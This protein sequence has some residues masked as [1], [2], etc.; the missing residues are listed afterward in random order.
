MENVDPGSVL[1]VDDQPENVALLADLLGHHG[2][3]VATAHDVPSA[4]LELE[5]VGP[6][7][8]LLDIR[9]PGM[10][11]IEWCRRLK[12]DPRWAMLPVVL[13]TALDP[14]AERV[15]GLEAGADDFL[16]K[17]IHA[18]E[19]LAR[20]R[21]LVRAKRLYDQTRRQAAELAA[22]NATLES[23]VAEKVAEVERLGR[24]KRFVAPQLAERLVAPGAPDPMVSHRRDIVVVF[25]DLRGFTAFA[26]SHD[27]EDVMS[28]LKAFHA[29]V[30]EQT[31]RHGGTIERYA[32]DGIMVFFND[33]APVDA[34]CE[35]AARYTLD[36]M[37]DCRVLFG[38][39]RRA[40]FAL[41]VGAGMAYGYATLGEIGWGDRI[42][43]GAIGTV[44]NLAS[45]LCAEAPP[46][47]VFAC[48]RVASELPPSFAREPLPPL[49]LKGIREPVAAV[50]LT[51]Q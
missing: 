36:V 24:L 23:R 15:G 13:V 51:V 28:A 34:P 48:P 35:R 32:G 49:T 47:A 42:D 16:S 33:P 19:M 20:V 8:V 37:T 50:R 29:V 6:D 27:P 39:L 9:L 7:V 41:D 45:R 1:V 11:G 4:E 43:Y 40:G 14:A 26:E 2:Y 46:G 10:N 21:S 22:M 30:G 5:R 31:R 44:T 17:P 38:R 3:R 12:T 18:E 25:F